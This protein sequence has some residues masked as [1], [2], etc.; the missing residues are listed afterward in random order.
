MIPQTKCPPIFYYAYRPFAEDYRM[1]PGDGGFSMTL[2][3]DGRFVI[4]AVD[5]QGQDRW[6]LFYDLPSAFKEKYREF[7]DRN[8]REISSLPIAIQMPANRTARFA[9]SVGLE[10][11]EFITC[12]DIPQLCH[13]PFGT[14]EGRSGRRLCTLMEDLAEVMEPFGIHLDLYTFY[15]DESVLP[16]VNQAPSDDTVW[17][18]QAIS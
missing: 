17:Q 8:N 13:L 16:R 11:F 1:D 15:V 5:L 2:Y 9:S 14:A 18:S 3:E 4:S 12:D 6:Q 10:G 7:L